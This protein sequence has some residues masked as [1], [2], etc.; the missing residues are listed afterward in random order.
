MSFFNPL[1]A[2]SDQHQNF[3]VLTSMK[4]EQESSDE[5]LHA[6]QSS[7][8]KQFDHSTNFLYNILLKENVS[9]SVRK[10]FMGT[11]RVGGP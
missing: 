8:R 1:S 4:N 2:K 9:K 10:I 7:Y 11:L 6:K 5:Y 3:S